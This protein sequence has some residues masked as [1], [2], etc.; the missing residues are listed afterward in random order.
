MSTFEEEIAEAE[1]NA[2]NA[3][4]RYKFMMFGEHRAT[5][6]IVLRS[7]PSTATEEEVTK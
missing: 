2:L 1:A 4:A 5:D 6:F 3:L 7:L